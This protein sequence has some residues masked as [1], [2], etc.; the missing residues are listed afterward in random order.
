MVADDGVAKSPATNRCRQQREFDRLARFSKPLVGG[1]DDK[2][3]SG[4]RREIDLSQTGR[5]VKSA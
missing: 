4:N 2:H 1:F 5:R 3:R